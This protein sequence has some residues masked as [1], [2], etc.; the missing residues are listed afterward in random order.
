MKLFSKTDL[1]GKIADLFADDI[2]VLINLP[3]SDD[4][5]QSSKF[6]W[7][8][9]DPEVDQASL[10]SGK[11]GLSD[12]AVAGIVIAC[13]LIVAIALALLWKYVPSTKNVLSYIQNEMIWNPR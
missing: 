9:N 7:Y 6:Q 11:S 12:G 5:V 1:I 2:G 8:T 4:N 13:L 10:R 3:T